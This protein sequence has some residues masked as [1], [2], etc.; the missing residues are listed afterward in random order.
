MVQRL[1]EVIK[2]KRQEKLA[3]DVLLLHENVPVHKNCIAMVALH[4]ALSD[5]SLHKSTP[6]EF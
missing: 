6:S 3:E 4:K 1:K 2:G 5:Y